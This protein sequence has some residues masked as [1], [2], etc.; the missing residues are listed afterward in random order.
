MKVLELTKWG[1]PRLREII[2]EIQ[3]AI[4]NRTPVAGL[5]LDCDECENGVQISLENVKGTPDDTKS[6]A[7][8]PSGGTTVNI[9]GALNGA[10]ATYHLLQSSPPTPL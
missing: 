7:G 5:G 3:N 4:N 1:P 2:G 10:P 8:A 9:V 6:G